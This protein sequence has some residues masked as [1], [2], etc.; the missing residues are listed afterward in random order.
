MKKEKL[1]E[2]AKHFKIDGE[3]VKIEVCESRTH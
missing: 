1:I 2:I 3:P